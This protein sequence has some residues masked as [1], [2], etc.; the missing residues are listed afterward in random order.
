MNRILLCIG[1]AVAGCS[2]GGDVAEPTAES[3]LIAR[4]QGDWRIALTPE[5][6]RQ[7][8]TMRFLL[9]EP[10]PNNDELAEFDLTESESR[11]AI[12]ILNEIRYDPDGERTKQ[13][14][15]AIAGLE[16]GELTIG[17]ERLEL[18]LGG[19]K[20]GGT[21]EVAATNGHSAHLRL[22]RDDGKEESV[23]LT[24]TQDHELLFGEGNDAVRFV[25]R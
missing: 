23:D 17:P 24:M 19:E 22:T 4:M 7:V 6:R 8:R 18:R 21:Y 16:Q 2:L 1:L 11:A 9:R 20:K 15:A 14:R 3:H 12:V 5:Q 13:L 25:K 10:P